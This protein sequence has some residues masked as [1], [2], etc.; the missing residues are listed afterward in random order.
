VCPQQKHLQVNTI[1]EEVTMDHL[2]STAFQHT[3]LGRTIL[4]PAQNIKSMTRD[5][6]EAYIRC[7]YTAG[8]PL[9]PA[10]LMPLQ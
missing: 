10:I 5:D 3:P 4:G 1:P 9:K 8:V 6:I 2:H 7:H